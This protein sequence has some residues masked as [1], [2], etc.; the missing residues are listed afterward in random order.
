MQTQMSSGR[1]KFLI[2]EAQAKIKLMS[3]KAGLAMDADKK[4][5]YLRPFTL[6]TILR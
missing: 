6:T 3:T 4:A 5:E 2:D 1:V